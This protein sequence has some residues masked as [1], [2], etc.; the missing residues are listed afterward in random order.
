M[1]GRP[2]MVA[3]LQES[4]LQVYTF[5]LGFS[6]NTRERASVEHL[7]RRVFGFARNRA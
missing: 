4:A 2:R 3:R 7:Y 1:P 6:A 5:G